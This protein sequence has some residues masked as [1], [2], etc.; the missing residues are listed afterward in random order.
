MY[1]IVASIDYALFFD[2]S[3]TNHKLYLP[4]QIGKEIW[5]AVT[6]IPTMALLTTPFFL[7]EVRGH[8][9]LYDDLRSPMQEILSVITYLIF[10]DFGIYCIHRGLHWSFIYTYIHKTHHRWV[11]CTPFASHGISKKKKPFDGIS[12]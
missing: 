6:S 5:V 12:N 2:K 8:S 9:Q 4:N 1:L 7:L 10:T 3:I 11:V